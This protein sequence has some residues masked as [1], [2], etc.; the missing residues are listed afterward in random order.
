MSRPSIAILLLL[1]ALLAVFS[2]SNA[3]EEHKKK[4]PPTT[5][6]IGIKKRVE[7]KRKSSDGCVYLLKYWD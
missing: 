1:L 4:T 6:Q 7:C 2:R 5:L 3:L